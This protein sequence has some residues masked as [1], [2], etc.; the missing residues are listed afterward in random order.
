MNLNLPIPSSLAQCVRP[1]YAAVLASLLNPS[2]LLAQGPTPQVI[3]EKVDRMSENNVAAWWSPI[4]YDPE[5][6]T[7]FMS[8]LRPGDTEKKDDVV[9]AMRQ[10]HGGWTTEDTGGKASFDKGHTQTSIALD[11]NGHLH[12]AYGMH[13]NP[14]RYG[15]SNEPHTIEAGIT[16]GAPKVFI[17]KGPAFTYPNMTTGKDGDVYLII[18]ESFSG[19][20]Y[21]YDLKTENWVREATFAEEEGSTVYP[22]HIFTGPKGYIHIIWE[23]AAGGP[24]GTRH[25]GSYTRYNP[26]EKTFHRADGTPHTTLPIT[27]KTADVYQPMEGNEVYEQGVHGIQSAKM[28][29]D[30]RGFP[31]IAYAYSAN[32]KGDGYEHRLAHWT[33]TTWERTTVSP[34]PFRSEKPWI[35]SWKGTLRYYS[36][37][38]PSESEGADDLHVR[39]STN[40]G[41]TWSTPARVTDNL[42]IARPVGVSHRGI[43]FLYLPSTQTGELYF[44]YVQY[45]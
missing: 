25:L 38:S 19:V 34:G 37:L 9:I 12:L 45:P 23:W 26:V 33:G 31:H 44:A 42:P 8:Y 17:A 15:I 7:V 30:D 29:V 35:S 21:R 32:Q 27:R 14:F 13:F 43:D 1:L 22:D 36:P 20:L 4:V 18:R 28:T 39:V 5:A 41:A 11:G 24:Q 16:R 2:L 3:L 40:F 6:R 10:S